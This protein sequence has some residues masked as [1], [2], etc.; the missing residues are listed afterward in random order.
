MAEPTMQELKN[1]TSYLVFGSDKIQFAYWNSS[2]KMLHHYSKEKNFIS[3]VG[4]KMDPVIGLGLG[5]S[6]VQILK[7]SIQL[8]R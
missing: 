6:Y 8:S 2:T 3:T 4:C 1:C 5:M 7:D